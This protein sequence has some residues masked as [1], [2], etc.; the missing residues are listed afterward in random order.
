VKGLV[1]YDALRSSGKEPLN[2]S[3]VVVVV[4]SSSST[5]SLSSSSGRVSLTP[6]NLHFSHNRS[7]FQL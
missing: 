4:T 5:L 2:I 6:S 3:V 7:F 1:G